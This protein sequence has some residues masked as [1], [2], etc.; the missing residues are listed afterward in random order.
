MG[1]QNGGLYSFFDCCSLLREDV[2]T[3]SPSM[4]HSVICRRT[5]HEIEKQEGWV[6]LP[7]LTLDISQGLTPDIAVYR[8]KNIPDSV[9]TL[10]L[11]EKAKVDTMPPLV[12]EVISFSQPVS[13]LIAKARRYIE[14]GVKTAIIL[15][16][17]FG[18]CSIVTAQEYKTGIT[19]VVEIDELKL[20]LS[21]IFR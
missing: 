12:I 4:L 9:D 10:I 21:K 7:E 5:I 11:E 1:E 19:G 18:V 14:A 17:Y 6:A 2:K 15:V 3:M 20:D 16:P 13:E 8:S